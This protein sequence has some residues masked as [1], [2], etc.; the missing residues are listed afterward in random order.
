VPAAGE[1]ETIPPQVA[2]H[3]AIAGCANRPRAKQSKGITTARLRRAGDERNMEFSPA[4]LGNSAN[5]SY[6]RL[7]TLTEF[8]KLRK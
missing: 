5:A 4:S 8:S 1:H 6:G 3:M 2:H 7:A